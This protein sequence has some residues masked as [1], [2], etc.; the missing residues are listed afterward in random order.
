LFSTGN[1]EDC[2]E[3]AFTFNPN[4]LFTKPVYSRNEPRFPIYLDSGDFAPCRDFQYSAKY[5]LRRGSPEST[6]SVVKKY[7]GTS[8]AQLRIFF[9][10]SVACQPLEFS[11]SVFNKYLIVDNAYFARNLL[12]EGMR[13]E[14]RQ[15]KQAKQENPGCRRFVNP[16]NPT[17]A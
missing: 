12:R 15:A 16:H 2:Q 6:L 5:F 4:S 7:F 1:V 17:P 8:R 11:G 9:R 3:P 14:S 10:P 13:C